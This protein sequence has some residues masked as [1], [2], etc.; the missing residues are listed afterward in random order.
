MAEEEIML[1]EE[2]IALEDSD[3]TTVT[4]VDVTNIIPFIMDRYQ[5]AED[6]RNNDEERWLRSYRNYRGLYGSDVQ[7]TEAEKSRVFIKV[8]K[9][10]TLAAYGQMVDVLF[11]GHKFPISVEPTVLPEGVVSD[12]SF[13]PKEPQELKGE[14]SL[15][16]PY[17]FE[18]DGKEFPTGATEKSL[19][20]KLGPLE[21]KLGDIEGIKEG[22]GK[23]PTSI[24]FSPAMIAAKNMEKKIMD[25]L[26][27]S[28]ANKQLRSILIG[29]MKV[30]IVLYLKL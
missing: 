17:G 5:R 12:V 26:Q 4:D 7:F 9:T 10:K 19:Q 11:A 24:T 23:T 2:S 30:T 22:I 27:E 28:G 16:S 1:D 18:G 14:T 3:E 8:T 15:S 6:Y 20:E 29:M 13:D 25:Q 21:E